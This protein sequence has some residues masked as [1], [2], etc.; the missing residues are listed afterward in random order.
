MDKSIIDTSCDSLP[1]KEFT[2]KLFQLQRRIYRAMQTG[3]IQDVVKFQKRLLINK[4]THLLA[5]RQ[6][7]NKRK[8]ARSDAKL[9]LSLSDNINFLLVTNKKLTNSKEIGIKKKFRDIGI[10]NS[11]EVLRI[12]DEI[13][14]C[15]WQYALEPVYHAYFFAASNNKLR[16]CKNTWEVQKRISFKLSQIV[17]KNNKKIVKIDIKSILNQIEYNTFLKSFLFPLKYKAGL[18]KN[19]KIGLISE[20]TFDN[21]EAER[22]NSIST[23]LINI[24]LQ[25]IENIKSSSGITTGLRYANIVV[26]IVDVYEDENKLLKEMKNFLYERG[27]KTNF[28]KIKTTLLEDGFNL[29]GWRFCIKHNGGIVNAPSKKNWMIYRQKV[30]RTLKNCKYPIEIRLERIRSLSEKWYFYHQ[31]SDMSQIKS[32][33]Y[34]LRKWYIRYLRN[35]TKIDKTKINLFAKKTFGFNFILYKK[36]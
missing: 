11:T 6:I 27:F 14:Q 34:S 3:N 23:L 4:S 20:G 28:L 17:Q 2:I 32:Q 36:L 16:A 1:W 12:E 18:M 35:N 29:F 9:V 8:M 10:R 24:A 5:I 22:N 13:V 25:G 19:L 30:K 15:I 7:I 26:Y 33:L 21:I 31:Y